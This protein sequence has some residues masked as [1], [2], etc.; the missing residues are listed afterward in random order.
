MIMPAFFGVGQ[1]LNIEGT[2]SVHFG[3]SSYLSKTSSMSSNGA[4]DSNSGA[5]FTSNSAVNS[6]NTIYTIIA[7]QPI[8]GNN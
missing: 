6:N 5:F 1:I 4:V 8:T 2:A 7:E 3:V